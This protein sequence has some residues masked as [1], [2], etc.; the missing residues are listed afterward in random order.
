[1]AEL[2]AVAVL[3]AA[4]AG[5]W[6]ARPSTGGRYRRP[7]ARRLRASSPRGAA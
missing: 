6:R 1:V 7:E 3:M 2:L 5:D 4:I